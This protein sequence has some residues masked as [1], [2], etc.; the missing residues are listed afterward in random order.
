MARRGENIYKRKDG[1]YEG[2]YVIGK[3]KDGRTKFGY[4]YG[5]QYI[6]VHNALIKMKASQLQNSKESY[7]RINLSQWMEDWLEKE[8]KTRIKASSYHTY[9]NIYKKHIKPHIGNFPIYQLVP[10]NVQ[11]FL[12]ILASEGLAARTVRGIFRLLHSALRSAQEEG[13][14]TKNPCRRIKL[15]DNGYKDQPVLN[16]KEQKVIHEHAVAVHD[17][18]S[19]LGLYTGMRLGEI[20]ALKWTDIDW[21]RKSI[22]WKIS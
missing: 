6:T 3:T 19:L 4:I 12:D 21:H 14:I 15:Q 5:R 20:C 2:R 8:Q 11:E 1:R 10:G 9:L 13:L 17:L 16:L 22:M 18:P 7:P